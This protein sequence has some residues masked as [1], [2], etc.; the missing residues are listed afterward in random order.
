MVVSSGDAE[1][2]SALRLLVEHRPRIDSCTLVLDEHLQA[3]IECRGDK[4]LLV[5]VPRTIDALAVHAKLRRAMD[6]F[7]PP[8]R[9]WPPE[10]G[11]TDGGSGAPAEVSIVRPRRSN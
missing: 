6:L 9:P 10:G 8:T 3:C 5:A 4:R 1:I 7:A 2:V 11:G